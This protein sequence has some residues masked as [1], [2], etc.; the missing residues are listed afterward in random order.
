VPL[1]DSTTF[2]RAAAGF[3][4]KGFPR[5]DLLP[6]V[7]PC[8]KIS[9]LSKQLTPDL[10]GKVPGRY[11]GDGEWV[12][13]RA[14]KGHPSML[15]EGLDPAT[16]AAAPE[17]PTGNV[18]LRAS[19]FPAIDID[20]KTQEA[21]DLA[22]RVVRCVLGGRADGPVR[23]RADAARSLR[24]FRLAPGAEPFKKRRIEWTD[25]DGVKHALEVLARGQQYV[26]AGVHPE[27]AR[28][29]W[30][31][32]KMPVADKL[33]VMT[34][35]DADVLTQAIA[36]DVTAA[37]GTVTV[38]ESST[39]G[40]GEAIDTRN[41][42]PTMPIAA[43]LEALRAIPNTPEALPTRDQFVA[44]LAS[45][46]AATGRN[47]DALYP[48][49]LQ[50][51]TTEGW[52]D[53]EYT[54]KVWDSLTT[55]RVPADHLRGLARKHGWEGGAAVDFADVLDGE[56]DRIIEKH[57][58]TGERPALH[59]PDGSTADTAT[60]AAILQECAPGAFRYDEMARAALVMRSPIGEKDAK[61]HPIQD[62][63]VV[64]VQVELQK[65]GLRRVGKE[66]VGDAILHVARNDA[67][68]PVRDWLGGLAWDGQERLP[69]LF[70]EYFG[71]A[72]TEYERAIGPMF[73]ISMVARVMQPG[74]KA[75]YMIV[76]EGA[77]GSRKS[78][79][80][81]I[82]GGDWFSD[83]LPDVTYKDAFQH[84][85]GK[86]LIEVAEMSAVNRAEANALKSFLTRTDERYRPSHGR[87]EVH[88]PRQVVFVGTTNE[89]E[90]LRDATG[91][92]RFWPVKTGV[93]DTD[94]LARDRDQLFAEALARYQRGEKWWPEG[95][96]EARVMRKEQ[97]AR[98]TA[99]PWEDPI[100]AFI[101]DKKTTT[102][103]EVAFHA[104][105][106]KAVGDM[107]MNDQKRLGDIMRRLEWEKRKANGVIKW[108]KREAERSARAAA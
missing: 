21:H 9:P 32:D 11:L 35:E 3:V 14:P 47:A 76:L 5:A 78:T 22:E 61:P 85:R 73:L 74:C 84:L 54:A 46:K 58:V 83:S 41:A 26:V 48:D 102:T 59:V 105:D 7:P 36:D 38:S 79:A 51:A 1:H 10:L 2:G 8:A 16:I 62:F 53:E 72:D 95:D 103:K 106:C 44:V 67:F 70:P 96:F 69:R 66:A 37:G 23:F 15:V 43:A 40:A 104:L 68:H 31:D 108:V 29:E 19:A 55:S 77:Q 28:Y 93:I 89:T 82:L 87:F 75:D 18:G 64:A 63:D 86:W 24:P 57:L 30:R 94:A 49:V 99:D 6:I 98:H 90:Y 20:T 65:R 33:P 25:K 39:G 97:E 60:V 52:A 12:G 92:R 45:F 81:K 88:E 101:A 50:W 34:A 107:S 4:A 13:L 100:A 71:S 56:I 27:G 42:D 91:A 80:A 17:W